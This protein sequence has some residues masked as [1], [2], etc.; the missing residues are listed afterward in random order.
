MNETEFADRVLAMEGTLFRV[1]SAILN[2]TAD[3]DDACQTAIL[4]AWEHRKSLRETRYFETWLTRICI[5]EC[6]NV[7]RRRRFF[8][9]VR[10]EAVEA[11]ANPRDEQVREALFQLDVKTR[12]LLVLKYAEMYSTREIAKMFGL[13]EG[14]VKG[15]LQRGRRKLREKLMKMEG[16]L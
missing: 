5:N 9:R 10:H 15:R 4:K 12:V 14:T 8:P 11:R 2:N 13:S 16:K 3:C 1:A 7:L 6:R